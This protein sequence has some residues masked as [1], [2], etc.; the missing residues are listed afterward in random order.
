MKQ[1]TLEQRCKIEALHD[2]KQSSRTIATKVGV[3]HST[4]CRE[5]KRNSQKGT[6]KATDAN[7]KTRQ[8]HQHKKKHKRFTP[9]VK[10]QIDSLILQKYSPDQ[11]AGHCKNEGIAMVTPERIYQY[12]W[13]DKANG[14]MLYTHLRHRGRQR[15]KRSKSKHSRSPI[16]NRVDITKRPAIV[17]QRIR[18]GDLEIDTIIGANRKGAI[19]TI[20][21]RVTGYLWAS[22]I[23]LRS[24][25]WTAEVTIKALEPLKDHIHTITS[26]NGM[27]FAQ[28]QQIAQ[29]LDIEFYFAHPYKSSQ[30]GS[31]ENTNGL[32]RQYIPKKTDFSNVTQEQLLKY[33]LQINQRPRKRHNYKSPIFMME[34]LLT[35][36][37][38][39]FMG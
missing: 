35:N 24:A 31:N 4:I 3:H 21:D 20:N 22:L 11:I 36:Q 8:R 39:A 17:E 34:S 37:G 10:H 23:P 33:C 15:R 13:H 2:E 38:V 16:V 1:L 28:H 7:Q 6:Y 30:R 12:I 9:E 27:E 26:D 25:I 14:G 19:V 29:E 5:I 32:L 18:L